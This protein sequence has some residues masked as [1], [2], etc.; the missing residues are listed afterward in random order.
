MAQRYGIRANLYDSAQPSSVENALN[1]IG[2]KS[3]ARVIR[4]IRLVNHFQNPL[5]RH[6]YNC[7]VQGNLVI[8]FVFSVFLL[9]KA[10]QNNIKQYLFSSRDCY[11]LHKIFDR[12]VRNCEF[13]VGCEYFFTSRL[14]RIKC[15]EDY[16]SYLLHLVNKERNSAIVDLAGTG[17]SLSYLLQKIGQDFSLP[18]IFFHRSNISRVKRIYQ[19]TELDNTIF[20]LIP[21]ETQNF[22]IDALEILNYIKQ[23]MVKDVLKQGENEYLPVFCS[24][25]IP[26][27]IF[28]LIDRTEQIIDDFSDHLN[29]EIIEEI[30]HRV[31]WGNLI[32]LSVAI[33]HQLC[34]HKDLFSYF[35]TFHAEEN[36]RVESELSAMLALG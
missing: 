7:F 10:E 16:L 13:P 3:L 27:E 2:A 25:P 1:E 15:S 5:K 4:K 12:M 33:Y 17:L 14:A 28:E 36:R 18:I 31:D 29:P 11:H 24:N 22:D 9:R 23:P 32:R 20:S 21:G 19:D 8:L 30:I 35:M 6:F 26:I 34:Q